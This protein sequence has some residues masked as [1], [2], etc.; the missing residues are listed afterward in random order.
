MLWEEVS[1]T[2]AGNA[3]QVRKLLAD[4]EARVLLVSSKFHGLRATMLFKRRFKTVG[5]IGS[6]ET[7][8]GQCYGTLREPAGFIKLWV[9]DFLGADE[10]AEV[11]G[12]R[13][14]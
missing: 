13:A 11:G 8:A 7:L 10:P 2:T 9:I 4:P 6:D 5:F 14:R 12:G 1:V 3:A